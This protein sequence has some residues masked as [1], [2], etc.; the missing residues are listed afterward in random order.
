M[1]I[2]EIYRIFIK[3]NPFE[4][5]FLDYFATIFFSIVIIPVE[6]LLSPLSIIV[7]IAYKI[8]KRRN[9]NAM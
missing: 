2:Y 8:H 9:N 1:I 4:V 3:E 5:E 7:L 6:I